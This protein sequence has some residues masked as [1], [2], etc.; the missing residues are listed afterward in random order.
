MT[1]LF[2]LHLNSEV[3]TVIYDFLLLIKSQFNV[4]V[5]VFRSDNDTEFFNAHCRDIFKAAG[6]IHQSSC[7]HTP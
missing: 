4:S 2:L 5:K 1:W 6:I 3:N 7:V